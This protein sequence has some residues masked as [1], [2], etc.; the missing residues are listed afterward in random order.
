[1]EKDTKEE[2]ISLSDEHLV[3]K[4]RHKSCYIHPKNDKLCIKF[5]LNE[6]GE[7]YFTKE[8]YYYG[9]R[10]KRNLSSDILPAYYG[11]LATKVDGEAVT[12]YVFDFIK[13]YDG[14]ASLALVDYLRSEDMLKANFDMLVYE[15][16]TLKN[17][18]ISQRVATSTVHPWNIV[19]QKT[20]EDGGKFVII[21][22]IGS[23]SKLPVEY[24][25]DFMAYIKIRRKW[26][27]TLKYMSKK[28]DSPL[29]H[30]LAKLVK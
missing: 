23:L 22:N 10:K 3:G 4:G 11:T 27:R 15:L 21:D 30:K 5:T 2:V 12:G 26:K 1:M 29:V 25:L 6:D 20:S 13:N 14:S 18:M 24:Y 17:S 19:Y 9:L 8:L 7:E 16:N 28:Y